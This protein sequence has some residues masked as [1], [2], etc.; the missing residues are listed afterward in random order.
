M[1]HHILTMCDLNE[2]MSEFWYLVIA[3]HAGYLETE[4]V[5]SLSAKLHELL[6]FKEWDKREK[7]KG[8]LI[9]LI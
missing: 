6:T 4:G 2:P 3:L 9:L 1:A 5:A 8:N 7:D